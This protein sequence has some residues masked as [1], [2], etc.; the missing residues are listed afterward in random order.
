MKANKAMIKKNQKI[1]KLKTNISN[2]NKKNKKVIATLPSMF[3][4]K[5]KAKR[6][7]W[8]NIWQWPAEL[9]DDIRQWFIVRSALKEQETIEKI[10]SFRYEIRK[11]NIGR[12]YTVINIPEELTPYDKQDMV[13]PWVVEQ[14][15]DIDDL[16]INR[17]LSDLMFPSIKRIEN[18]S[19]YL[20]I[21]A[22]SS[23][24]LSLSKL[25]SWIWN[26]A[27][28]SGFVYVTNQIIYNSFNFSCF[29]FILSIF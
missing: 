2:L 20:V 10:A 8:F 23:E 3:L 29:D 16:L 4:S 24:S 25:F 14:L 9:V 7:G 13:W 21:L 28:T 6:M 15:R 12:L 5:L 17:Q 19:A 11:D 18:E 22:S 1:K 26:I 27:F